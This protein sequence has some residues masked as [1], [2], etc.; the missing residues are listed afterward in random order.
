[1]RSEMLRGMVI[2]DPKESSEERYCVS[3]QNLLGELEEQSGRIF[4]MLSNRV[5]KVKVKLSR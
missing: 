4:S 1:M 2:K 5:K 3:S